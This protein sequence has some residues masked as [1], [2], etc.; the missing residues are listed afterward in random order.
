MPPFLRYVISMNNNPEI[1][2]SGGPGV[3]FSIPQGCLICGG[4]LDVR[5]APGTARSYC[6]HCRWVSK[7]EVKL[8]KDG[9]KVGHAIELLA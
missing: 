5:I 4:E 9:V 7:P 8:E 3:E 6:K 1:E 2:T